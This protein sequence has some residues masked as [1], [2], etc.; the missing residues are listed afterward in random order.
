LMLRDQNLYEATDLSSCFT[1]MNQDDIHAP[2]SHVGLQQ[3]RRIQIRTTH[4]KRKDWTSH[5][6][7]QTTTAL[8]SDTS[9]RVWRSF[10]EQGQKRLQCGRRTI[11]RTPLRFTTSFSLLRRASSNSLKEQLLEHITLHHWWTLL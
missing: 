10:M 11:Y 8:W 2:S 5:R 7:S 1:N 3:M 9:T 6:F 4:R